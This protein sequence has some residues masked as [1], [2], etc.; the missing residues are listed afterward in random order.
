M[1]RETVTRNTVTRGPADAGWPLPFAVALA[2]AVLADRFRGLFEAAVSLGHFRDRAIGVTTV[3]GVDASPYVESYVVLYGSFVVLLTAVFFAGRWVARRLAGGDEVGR[4]LRFAARLAEAAAT[5]AAL[6]IVLRRHDLDV[7]AAV[8]LQAVVL[9]VAYAAVKL[10]ILERR[11]ESAPARIVADVDLA[12]AA[13]FVPFAAVTAVQTVA[14]L[15]LGFDF[16]P[17]PAWPVL[18]GALAAAVLALAARWTASAEGR[19]RLVL[20]SAPLAFIPAAVPLANELQYRVSSVGPRA[21]ATAAILA[22]AGAAVGLAAAH[23]RGLLAPRPASVLGLVVFPAFLASNVLFAVHEHVLHFSK[24]DYFHLGESTLPTQQLFDY[25]RLP[26]LDVRLAHTFSDMV[27]QTLYTLLNGRQ[28]LDMLVW[29]AWMPTVVAVVAV[30]FFLARVTSPGFALVAVAVTG[31]LRTVSEYY[32]LALVPPIFLAAAIRR[33]TAAR[34][35]LLWAGIAAL[36]LWRFDFGL[37]AAVAAGLVTAG[38][39]ARRRPGRALPQ[40]PAHRARAVAVSVAATAG[41]LLVALAAA[42]AAGGRPVAAVAR[43]FF[44]SYSYRLVTRMRSAIIDDFGLAAVLQYYVLPAVA[45]AVIARFLTARLAGRRTP[46]VWAPLV[47]VA[48]FSLAMSVRSLERHSLI[49]RFNPYLFVF[50]AALAPVLFLRRRESAAIRGVFL[51]VVAIQSIAVLPPARFGVGRHPLLHVFAAGGRLFEVRA[52]RGDEPRVSFPEERHRPLLSFL[53]RHLDE[54]QTF[55]DFSNSPLLYVLA[56]RL[57][58]THVIPNLIHTSEPVQ[59]GVTADLEALRAAGR[60]PFVIFKQGDEFWDRADGVPNEIRS[61]RVA[62]LVYRHYRPLARVG[63]YE[64]WSERG[65]DAAAVLA[66]ELDRRELAFAAAPRLHDVERLPDGGSRFRALAGDPWIAGLFELDDQAPAAVATLELRYAAA[67][68][69]EMQVFFDLAGHGFRE[70]ASA[71]TSLVAA[72]PGEEADRLFVAAPGGRLRD[73]RFD[74]PPGLALEIRGAA[75]LVAGEPI[76]PILPER[77]AQ[78]FDLGR[79]PAVWGA[80]DPLA[81]KERTA[82]LATLAAAPFTLEAGAAAAFDFD[83]A[84]DKSAGNYL[85]LRLR[86]LSFGDEDGGSR[87]TIRYG[88]AREGV[89]ENGFELETRG[90]APAGELHRLSPAPKDAFAAHAVERFDVEGGRMIYRAT[91]EDPHFWGVL[92][93]GALPPRQGD[94]ELVLRLRYHSSA[95]GELQVFYAFDGRDFAEEASAKAA[96]E[97]TS[98]HGD[99][100]LVVVPLSASPG[101]ELRALRF[102]LPDAVPDGALFEIDGAEIVYR[103]VSFEDHLVRLSSQWSWTSE[104]VDRLVLETDG[105]VMVDAVLIRAGD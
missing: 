46:A 84:I 70:A 8:L 93:L 63:G 67:D 13:L 96:I 52:W 33:P 100:A 26:I 77:V 49:E 82:V 104:P 23:R 30:Y 15:R 28:G 19:A 105:P 40:V 102:D 10:R 6:A 72:G 45:V 9:V 55:F 78:R 3:D 50:L 54:D 39:L 51:A 81:A 98:T 86:P 99:P 73:V 103:P 75:L 87:V 91:G 35:A 36:G 43:S 32:A 97:A 83:P 44:D 12:A 60:L 95:A 14:G 88:L 41:T 58:P 31:V 1:T 66:S 16:L 79:L 57:F 69:G 7:L 42:A 71:W 76:R 92:D 85:Q 89:L 20:A 2:L 11:G 68:A 21:L 29:E 62:E 5:A 80:F 22:L 4:E 61:Y 18:Y 24:L 47:M 17:P 90:R 48:A 101:R 37:T 38:W 64:L 56:D 27:F 59:A 53:E 74:P 65:V 25:G 34:F 94:T